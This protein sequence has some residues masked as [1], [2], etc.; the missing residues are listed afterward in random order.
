M[1]WLW[2]QLF[3]AFKS[4][5]WTL[6][7]SVVLVMFGGISKLLKEGRVKSTCDVI[8]GFASFG[9]L[10]CLLTT[11]GLAIGQIEP[12]C[13]SSLKSAKEAENAKA[14]I[15]AQAYYESAAQQAEEQLHPS[16]RRLDSTRVELVSFMG[17]IK[18]WDKAE[19]LCRNYISRTDEN[20]GPLSRHSA[21]YRRMLAGILYQDGKL[22]EAVSYIDEVSRQYDQKYGELDP[23]AINFLDC[24]RRFI[25]ASHDEKQTAQLLAEVKRRMAL[26]QKSE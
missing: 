23:E 10:F 16:D 19:S 20:F 11:I 24:K 25:E 26:G 1:D 3:P 8:A 22:N 4:A 14:P 18:Q 15:A 13:V 12:S 7:C 5:L 21:P 9:A 6:V 2:I 17:R